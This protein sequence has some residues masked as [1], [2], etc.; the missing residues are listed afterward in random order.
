[1]YRKI[2]TY[3]NHKAVNLTVNQKYGSAFALLRRTERPLHGVKA[4]ASRLRLLGEGL[5]APR[6]LSTIKNRL[7]AVITAL[8]ALLIRERGS[9]YSAVKP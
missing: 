3:I 4:E 7:A 1:M 5:T 9:F 2:P 8:R 6:K